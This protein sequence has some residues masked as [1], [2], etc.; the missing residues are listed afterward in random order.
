[1]PTACLSALYLYRT[2]HGRHTDQALTLVVE[3]ARFASQVETVPIESH[4][5]L[6]IDPHTI[7]Y[8]HLNQPREL[9]K[10][11]VV[12]VLGNVELGPKAVVDGNLVK[13]MSWY[14]NEMGYTNTL[15]LH[16]LEVAKYI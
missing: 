1:M 11:E 15:V 3:V 16:T 13:V 10:G 5:A 14:D 8:N 7:V 4:H 6:G 9:V 2:L 12:T